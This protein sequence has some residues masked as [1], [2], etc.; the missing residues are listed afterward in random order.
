[1][2]TTT[3]SS[4]AKRSKPSSSDSDEDDAPEKKKL[5]TTTAKQVSNGGG[6]STTARRR[7]EEPKHQLWL[8]PQTKIQKRQQPTR[9]RQLHPHHQRKSSAGPPH[10]DTTK[11]Q[12]TNANTP[13][14]ASKSDTKK[15]DLPSQDINTDISRRK[16][17]VL[18]SACLFAANVA[19][20]AYIFSQHTFHNLA[21]MK[22]ASTVNKLQLE[23]SD[24]KDEMK[25]LRKAIETLEGRYTNANIEGMKTI[26]GSS[27]TEHK[28]F[29]TSDEL[30]KWKHWLN[31]L[32]KERLSTM[33]DF[34]EKMKSLL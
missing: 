32:E 34:N 11:A 31:A 7:G 12:N 13:A 5:R 19:S 21:Q 28:Q 1:M 2:T 24:A 29:L 22:C 10:A 30:L 25:L 23:L 6:S 4:M 27:L 18:L 9:R 3:N 14:G 16:S 26:F 33:N 17:G 15:N 20:A 8:L